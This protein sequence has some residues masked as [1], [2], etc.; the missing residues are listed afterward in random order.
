M[1][2]QQKG[3][4]ADPDPL[5]LLTSEALAALLAPMPAES[6]AART[7]NAGVRGLKQADEAAPLAQLVPPT[8]VQ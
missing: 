6:L 7:T 2:V 1:E 8:S 3:S 5:A 4:D